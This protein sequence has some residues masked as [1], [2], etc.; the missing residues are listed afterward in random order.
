MVRLRLHKRA[1]QPK[2]L[3]WERPLPVG[4]PRFDRSV[5]TAGEVVEAGRSSGAAERTGPQAA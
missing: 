4:K 5:R 3:D 2:A 1:R